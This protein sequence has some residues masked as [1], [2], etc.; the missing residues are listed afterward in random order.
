M[1]PSVVQGNLANHKQRSAVTW[2]TP[3]NIKI[4]PI[5]EMLR[6]VIGIKRN[7]ATN[8]FWSLGGSPL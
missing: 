3:R 2:Y 4:K 8:E 5:T 7:E 1:V 6:E